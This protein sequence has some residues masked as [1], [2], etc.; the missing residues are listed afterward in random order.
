MTSVNQACDKH[1]N[2]SNHAFLLRRN[3]VTRQA[4]SCA[5]VPPRWI[6]APEHELYPD[7]RGNTSHRI[8][9][10]K[11]NLVSLRQRPGRRPSEKPSFSL[12]PPPADIDLR[13][14]SPQSVRK[15]CSEINE[16]QLEFRTGFATVAER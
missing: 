7:S 5:W 4:S 1:K 13:N 2:G 12:Q 10:S 14:P 11:S 15:R 16:C 9:S 6:A 8:W 3:R